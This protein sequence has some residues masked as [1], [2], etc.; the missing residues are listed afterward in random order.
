MNSKLTE[1][2]AEALKEYGTYRYKAK[3]DTTTYSRRFIF[4]AM[5]EIIRIAMHNHCVEVNVDKHKVHEDMMDHYAK[6]QIA[7]Q[8]EIDELDRIYK[9]EPS[10]R[11]KY[12]TWVEENIDKWAEK[13]TEERSQRLSEKSLKKIRKRWRI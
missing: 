2:V 13:D 11:L 1:K 9:L 10:K 8:D 6:D 7:D 3:N 12:E 4:D 5:I